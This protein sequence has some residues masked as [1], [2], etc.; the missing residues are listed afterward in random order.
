M[1]PKKH[2]LVKIEL[3]CMAV[4]EVEAGH[5]SPLRG[6]VQPAWWPE[7]ACADPTHRQASHRVTRRGH[8]VGVPATSN[9]GGDIAADA[10]TRDSRAGAVR[11]A[12]CEFVTAPFQS[13]L[14]VARFSLPVPSGSCH[15]GHDPNDRSCRRTGYAHDR[16]RSGETLKIARIRG[17]EWPEDPR[18]GLLR[19][20]KKSASRLR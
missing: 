12:S 4:G 16:G 1:S 18:D 13:G 6:E 8:P 14:D 15:V 7:P 5:T 20:P 3:C 17:H 2:D 9:D 10:L 19:D 11:P